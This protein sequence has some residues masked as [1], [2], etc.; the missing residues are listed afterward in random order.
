MNNTKQ[1]TG[2]IDILFWIT[3]DKNIILKIMY[4][5]G[6]LVGVYFLTSTR[7][8][9]TTNVFVIAI[10]NQTQNVPFFYL[11]LTPFFAV[12]VLLQIFSVLIPPLKR[13][14]YEAQ[15]DRKALIQLTLIT[16]IPFTFIISYFL[17]FHL[18]TATT[19]TLGVVVLIVLA[20]IINKFGIGNGYAWFVVMF[21]PEKLYSIVVEMW[22][23]RDMIFGVFGVVFYVVVFVLF[24]W[25]I[26]KFQKRSFPTNIK[27]TT[28]TKSF[29][30]HT[31]PSFLGTEPLGWVSVVMM[32]P[33]L[34][35]SDIQYGGFDDI[36]ILD[37]Y[38]YVI[39]YGFPGYFFSTILMSIFAL[40]YSKII[41]GI[42]PMESICNR[43]Q[44]EIVSSDTESSNGLL[45]KTTIY[46][47]RYTV[48]LLAIMNLE[49]LFWGG[50]G[51]PSVVRPIM[52]SFYAFYLMG[53]LSDLKAHL[54]FLKS[55][56]EPKTNTWFLCD[57]TFDEIEAEIKRNLLINNGID[58]MVEPLRFT[59][60]MPIR[61]M[62]DE[63]RLYVGTNKADTA[64]EL[65]INKKSKNINP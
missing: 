52:A 59:W 49:N 25:F 21:I 54:S 36:D 24:C 60:G 23:R 1:K 32:I 48:F 56:T 50:F 18:L 2:F 41:M 29:T 34:F 5:L 26:Y 61:T 58:A 55:M 16:M 9:E 30:I 31:R 37:V 10:S 20:N 12:C 65:L 47:L 63:Y 3:R 46:S 27:D 6:I 44:L 39:S 42:N 11:G 13:C 38:M 57:I 40:L 8:S 51:M 64:K 28:Q 33:F 14:L 19:T 15:P 35:I 43:Y 53:F 62:V 7:L 17:T 4:T 22:T 45:N